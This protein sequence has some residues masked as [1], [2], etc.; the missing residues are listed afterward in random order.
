MHYEMRQ[1]PESMRVE[2]EGEFTF[3]DSDRFHKMMSKVIANAAA[4]D[5][6][7]DVDRLKRIDTSALDM[8][9]EAIACAKQR[10]HRL[11]IEHPHGQVE[12]RLRTAA[13]YNNSLIIVN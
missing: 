8:L 3:N 13:I 2:M 4:M 6:R 11:M 7:M 1:A 9:I 10:H 12:Q 5:I